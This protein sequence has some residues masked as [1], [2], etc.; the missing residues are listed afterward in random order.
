MRN[1]YVPHIGSKTPKFR[2]GGFHIRPLKTYKI[3][4]IFCRGRV[5]VPNR[6]SDFQ[7]NIHKENTPVFIG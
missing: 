5:S 3:T 7:H 1:Y 2:R 4:A 6:V